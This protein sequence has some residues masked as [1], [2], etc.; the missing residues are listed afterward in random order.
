MPFNPL[1]ICM[2]LLP[3][4]RYSMA[5]REWQL[6]R[7]GRYVE[8][9]LVYDRGTKF[10]LA[11]PQ[12]RIESIFISMPLYARWEYRHEVEPGSREEKLQKVLQEPRDW[13]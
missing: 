11:T 7:R 12:A 3:F 6:L 10:G 4:F 5:D 13:L 2:G 8:Y 9:N 1:A